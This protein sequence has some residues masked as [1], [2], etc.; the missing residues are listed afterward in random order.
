VRRRGERKQ[1]LK[2]MQDP[3]TSSRHRRQHRAKKAKFSTK[4]PQKGGKPLTS[5]KRGVV[6][7]GGGKKSSREKT[8][9]FLL[10]TAPPANLQ[11]GERNGLGWRSTKR[12]PLHRKEPD[13]RKKRP[14]PK[15]GRRP[16]SIMGGG[17]VGNLQVK[18]SNPKGHRQRHPGGPTLHSR[19][20]DHVS[21][22]RR[23]RN[24]VSAKLRFP[25][26]RQSELGRGR[27]LV[28]SRGE[29]DGDF[30]GAQKKKQGVVGKNAVGETEKNRLLP[31]K[32]RLA[33]GC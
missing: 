11:G 33:V 8:P 4:N 25:V 31:P 9:F 26:Q 21:R 24:T 13:K 2:K 23:Q 18:S 32:G 15:K 22:R 17:M 3:I 5:P 12:Q 27:N 14:N 29:G 7:D 30:T 20:D 1:N 6:D 28:G 16:P 10:E 19:K